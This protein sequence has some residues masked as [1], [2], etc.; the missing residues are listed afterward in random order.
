MKRKRA[1]EQVEDRPLL[2]DFKSMYSK[3]VENG[4]TEE[5]SEETPLCKE[6]TGGCLLA[7]NHILEE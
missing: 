6:E 1:Q 7:L 4:N 3:G 5:F 2:V